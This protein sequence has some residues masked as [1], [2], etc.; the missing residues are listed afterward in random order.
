M[1]LRLVQVTA[2]LVLL[3]AALALPAAAIEVS[4][5]VSET[6]IAFEDSVRFEITVEWPGPQSAYAFPRPLLP[7]FDRLRVRGFSSSISTTGSGDS[8]ITRKL[9]QYTLVPESSGAGQINAVTID[10]I[11]TADDAEGTLTTEPMTITI[12]QPV[13]QPPPSEDSWTAAILIGAIIVMAG[14]LIAFF[15]LRRKRQLATPP[16][17]SPAD[18]ALARLEQLKRDAGSDLKKFQTG[19]H[20]LLVEYAS[21]RFAIDLSGANEDEV[22]AALE[23]VT[24]L[25][26][27]ERAALGTWVIKARRDKF[28]PLTGEPGE[29]LRLEVEIRKFIAEHDIG[30]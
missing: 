9:Y 13:P 5:T 16:E 11:A 10:Y 4:Q 14:G 27:G 7:T 21:E 12:A 22:M 2:V 8:A 15:L 26:A 19:L 30:R 29:T 3:V 17:R 23:T 28:S 1:N 25:S 18:Q 24:E 20:P 6:R